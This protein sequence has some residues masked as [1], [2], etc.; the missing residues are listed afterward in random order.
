MEVRQVE[1]GLRTG[2]FLK[3][4]SLDDNGV[5]TCRS[6]N[7]VGTEERNASLTVGCKF[8]LVLTYRYRSHFD[9]STDGNVGS[10]QPPYW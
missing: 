7:N 3:D 9:C 5:Y 4:L 1:K 10:P 2:L 8:G 6:S